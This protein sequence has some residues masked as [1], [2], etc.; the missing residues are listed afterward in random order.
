MKEP[1]YLSYSLDE[2]TPVYGGEIGAF[3]KK[4]KSAI[5]NGDTANSLIL[6]FP[7]HIGTHIDFPYHFNLNGKTSSDYPAAFWIFS[8]VGFISGSIEDIPKKISQLEEDIDLL[9]WKSGF[10]TYRSSE[11][12]WKEQP[13]IPSSLAVLFRKRFPLLRVFGFDMIS[14]TSKLDRPEGRKAHLQFLI[15][16]DILLLEDMRL[17]HLHTSPDT[18]IILPLQIAKSDGAPCTVIAY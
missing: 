16:S 3:S 14:M 6:N 2:S 4:K 11:R 13:V 9:I 10:G 5:E 8:K 17:E 12:Y 7:N 15:D 18:V 1:L